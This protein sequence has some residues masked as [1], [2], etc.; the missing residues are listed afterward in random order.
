MAATSSSNSAAGHTCS[1][2]DEPPEL[3]KCEICRLVLRDPQITECCG[4]NACRPCIIKVAENDGPCPICR[5]PCVKINF[6]R[7]LYSDILESKVYC[8]WKEA[9]CQWADKLD[10][11]DKHIKEDC[12]FVEEE[13]QRRCGMRI[14]RRG[15]K[16]HETICERFPIECQQCGKAVYE[17]RN[18]L[19]HLKACPFTR[20]KCPFNIVGCTTEVLNKDLQQHFNDALPEHYA[21]VSKQTEDVQAQ[22]EET[23]LS[24]QERKVKQVPHT[25]EIVT[26]NDEVL[27]AQQRVTELQTAI[28]E[29]EQ[30]FEEL[31]KT[32]ERM[33]AEL[34]DQAHQRD[35]TSHALRE[36][37][38]KLVVESKVRCYGPA[39]PRPH[40]T[41]IVS[42][43]LHCPPTT[44]ERIP[45][46]SFMI[47]NFDEERKNDALLCLPPFFSHGGGYKMCLVVR[48][49]GHLDAKDKSLSI[50]VSILNGRYDEHLMWPLNCKVTIEVKNTLG[51]K[52]NIRRTIEV[53]SH[54]RV[55]EDNCIYAGSLQATVPLSLLCLPSPYLKD[56]CLTI[57]VAAVQ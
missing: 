35:T 12:P 40:P 24:V 52:Q 25:A 2:V 50:L 22:V 3:F 19:S 37:L 46:L 42:R 30:E 57:N 45:P 48:C 13:C 21:L 32:H 38:D 34:R 4:K 51:L 44:E 6:N 16:D 28:V 1:F 15:I 49:N 14:Q 26:H 10:H 54:S 8:L 41:E 29:A 43:P 27:A 56:G 7:G 5:R 9:G 47:P 18:E 53:K 23:K 55:L 20:V 31:Q 39:L 11:L 17:R 33:K 36:E